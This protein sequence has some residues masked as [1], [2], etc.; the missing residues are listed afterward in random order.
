MPTSP[1]PPPTLRLRRNSPPPSPRPSRDCAPRRWWTARRASRSPRP[2][3]P[4]VGAKP[5]PHRPAH[6]SGPSPRPRRLGG[7][8]ELPRHQKD[9]AP[10]LCQLL[11]RRLPLHQPL[12]RE[13]FRFGR[14]WGPRI[15]T[16]LASST[17]PGV[18]MR[19]PMVRQPP[20]SAA[21]QNDARNDKTHAR[22]VSESQCF[23]EQRSACDRHQNEAERKQRVGVGKLHGA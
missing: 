22:R 20:A 8:Q 1:H 7:A 23:P 15:Y 4:Q 10:V 2:L 17:T 12:G 11:P 5:L 18:A 14:G 19:E 9:P 21:G 3:N 16:Q 13:L 6:V